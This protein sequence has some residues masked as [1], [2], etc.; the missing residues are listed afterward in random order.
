MKFA[1]WRGWWCPAP[2]R[3]CSVIVLP[4]QGS[5]HIL[6]SSCC[7]ECTSGR[8]SAGPSFFSCK[9]PCRHLPSRN[10]ASQRKGCARAL[11]METEHQMTLDDKSCSGRIAKYISHMVFGYNAPDEPNDLPEEVRR[12]LGEARP[13]KEGSSPTWTY[14]RTPY[15][16]LQE[17]SSL[18]SMTRAWGHGCDSGRPQRLAGRLAEQ[19]SW[20]GQAVDSSRG[21]GAP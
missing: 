3:A 17:R 1:D 21:I 20:A 15:V 5:C 10:V 6:S 8:R 16:H 7:K 13:T 9:A 18:T 11:K 2:A 4:H 14:F 12:R 19:H